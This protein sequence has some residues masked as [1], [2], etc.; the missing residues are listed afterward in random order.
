MTETLMQAEE[1]L[2]QGK[3][4]AARAQLAAYCARQA[5]DA[6]AWFLLGA[7]HHQA[8]YAADALQ[9]FLR[10]LSLDPGNIQAL[11]AQCA[12]LGEL[13]R[14][15]EALQALCSV[16][17]RAPADAKAQMYYSLA[18]VQEHLG[19][20]EAALQS[21]EEALALEPGHAEAALNRG[22]LLIA[23]GRGAAAL[24]SSLQLARSHP[25]WHAAQH[26][27]GEA[28][29][30]LG[31]WEEALAAYDEALKRDAR[32]AKTCFALGLALSM[33]RRFDEARRFFATAHAQD[34]QEVKRCIAT[35]SMLAGE[36]MREVSP[37][38]FYLLRSTHALEDCDWSSR[39][40]LL[41]ELPR[42]VE[43][44]QGTSLE[45]AEEALVFRTLALPL[46]LQLRLTLAQN[47][48]RRIG[49]AVRSRPYPVFVEHVP[50]DRQRLRI[51]YVS[52]D[53]GSHPVGRLTR[54]LYHLHARK[55]FEVYGYALM[56]GDGSAIRR[57]IEQGCDQFRTLQDMSDAE[58]ALAIHADGIDILVNLAGYTTHARSGIFA[59]RPAPLQ[60]SY[61][62]FPGSMGADFMHYFITDEVCSPPGQESQFTEALA[63]LPHTC[64]IYNDR[65]EIAARPMTREE[66]GLPQEGFVFCCF[67]NSYKI[68]P[69]V[70]DVWMRI[71]ERTPGSVFWL[72]GK[73]AAVMDN[74]RRE[75]V[76][77]GVAAE[78]LVFASFMADGAAH[79][80]RYRLA[81][82]FLDTLHFNAATTAAD[83][84]WAGL[85]LLT[86]PGTTF[87]A[88]WAASI[89][90]GAGMEEMI[91]ASLDEY[92]ERACHLALHPQEVVRLKAQLA[93]NR[94]RAPL[95]DTERHV[96]SLE[97]AYLV[98]WQRHAEGLPPA[99]FKVT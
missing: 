60:V 14:W 41:T 94:D 1:L 45:I 50:H 30:A 47:S 17:P 91:C 78:R 52:P 95:F 12:V 93:Q 6:R 19:Q 67:N 18:V 74:L 42:L 56:P 22:A 75:A 27:V 37:E 5:Q 97:K 23:L 89:L 33:L 36:E 82:V 59:L 2:R 40:M 70:F 96:R 57:D 79:L 21:Y 26:N 29:L 20:R 44:T 16:L 80:A 83:A 15:Q 85:P 63:W 25:A 32:A 66:F 3:L 81:D 4:Q 46:S 43:A 92:E 53:F 58:A 68:D 98:M 9:A 76:L 87:I 84:L 49:A 71:L 34:S 31:R 73:S 28:Y 10:C 7:A 62:G 64:M 24:E 54:R 99:S 39:D 35:A 69:A 65:E 8:G 90:T 61:N 13:G 48:A 88:R 11:F 72:Y 77:R 86:C 38:A 55:D 51:G